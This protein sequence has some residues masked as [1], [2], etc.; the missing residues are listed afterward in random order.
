MMANHIAELSKALNVLF[1]TPDS[2]RLLI[3]FVRDCRM[4]GGTLFLAGNGGSFATALH[5]ACDLTKVCAVRTH[6]LGANGALLSAWANDNSYAGALAEEF[7]R[8]ARLDDCLIALSCSGIS[9]NIAAA[10]QTARMRLRT[11]PIAHVRR[12]ALLT[13]LVNS[14]V[15]PADLTIRVQ[16]KDYK[17]IEDCHLIIGHWLTKELA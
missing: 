17:V 4:R 10:L 9:P 1:D 13:G 8:Y 15:A 16:S 7:E 5:W 14:D 2:A 3:P 12:T 11:V 6:V